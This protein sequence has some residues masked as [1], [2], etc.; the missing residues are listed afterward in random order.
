MPGGRVLALLTGTDGF[1]PTP[2]RSLVAWLAVTSPSL[3][4]T[5]I[6]LDPVAVLM[7]GDVSCF[8][9]E[10]K[11]RL[12]EQ[13]ADDPSRLYEGRWRDS[14]LAG[15]ASA[16]MEP[17]LRSVL[18]DPDR[19]DPKQKVAEIVTKALTQAPPNNALADVLLVVC[20]DEKRWFRVRKPA[21]D[22][23]I[24]HIADESTR[25][26]RLLE[27]LDGIRDGSIEDYGGEKLGTL[28]RELYPRAIGPAELWEYFPPSLRAADR[29]VLP[30]LERTAGHLS[31]RPSP[32][33][34]GLSRRLSRG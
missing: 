10:E 26:D 7:Y 20:R 16:D 34:S 23:W 6:T 14:A 13:I 9:P 33:P 12:L 11:T 31:G 29:P 4:K 30:V 1:P 5:L 3:R 32:G 18:A 8:K 17:T 21:L 19:S 27:A 24:H 15:L 28:L 25:D 22:A 2:L